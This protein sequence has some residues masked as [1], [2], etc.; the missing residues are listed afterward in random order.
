VVHNLDGSLLS[1]TR[2]ANPTLQITVERTGD[3]ATLTSPD[4]Q[5]S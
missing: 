4:L 1:V 5:T 2:P 3:P